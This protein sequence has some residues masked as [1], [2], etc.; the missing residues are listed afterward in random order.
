MLPGTKY[1]SPLTRLPRNNFDQCQFNQKY[2]LIF[3]MLN[4]FLTQG[5]LSNG[6]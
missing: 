3:C 6:V 4:Q 2:K 1:D 5:N